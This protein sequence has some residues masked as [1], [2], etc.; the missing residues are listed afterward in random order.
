MYNALVVA[1]NKM[2]YIIEMCAS[3]GTL[4]ELNSKDRWKGLALP[5]FNNN[6]F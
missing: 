5:V 4:I 3:L 1:K 6:F 2:N